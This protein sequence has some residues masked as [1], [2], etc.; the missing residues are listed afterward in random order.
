MRLNCDSFL[1]SKFQT[2]GHPDSFYYKLIFLSVFCMMTP[3]SHTLTG[4]MNVMSFL[5]C[6]IY[7]FA[8]LWLGR[9]KKNVCVEGLVEG[10]LQLARGFLQTLQLN[11]KNTHCTKGRFA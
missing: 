1:S 10:S 8:D 5:F 9:W 3:E 4:H 11:A 6:F 7:L 2:L